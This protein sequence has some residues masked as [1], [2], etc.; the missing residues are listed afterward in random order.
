MGLLP[1]LAPPD[2]GEQGPHTVSSCLS[3][4][5]HLSWTWEDFL[6]TR[7]NA[8]LHVMQT[9]VKVMSQS[10]PPPWPQP[11]FLFVKVDA[12][13][14]KKETWKPPARLPKVRD[15]PGETRRAPRPSLV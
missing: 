5:Q 1:P 9:R 11:Q 13:L 15:G 14:A 2:Q 3:V 10:S 8:A 6:G 12:G 4:L 7:S